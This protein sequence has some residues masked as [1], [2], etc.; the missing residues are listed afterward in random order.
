MKLFIVLAL[1]SVALATPLVQPIVMPKAPLPELEDLPYVPMIEPVAIKP[2]FVPQEIIDA[3]KEAEQPIPADAQAVFDAMEQADDE[4]VHVVDFVEY[5]HDHVA[6]KEVVAAAVEDVPAD[7]VKFVEVAENAEY[8]EVA[9]D[10]DI[11]A[12]AV[13]FVEVAENSEVAEVAAPAGEDIIP[14]AVNV[15]DVAEYIEY[16]EVAAPAAKE[17]AADAIKVVDVA[18]NIE[19]SNVTEEEIA[20]PAAEEIPADAV[21]FVD[22]AENVDAA[23]AEVVSAVK[24]VD[25]APVA[26]NYVPR[27]PGKIYDN[28]M[29]R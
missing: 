2:L 16:S 19:H 1:A 3:L 18:E 26:D 9:A 27:Y 24:V 21:K 6:E 23:A 5:D 29:L 17:I 8:S 12:D 28:A 4:V 20:A 15:V 13:K 10:E 7:A 22:N 11:P 14:D 25:V